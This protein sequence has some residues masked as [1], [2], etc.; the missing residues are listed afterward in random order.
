MSKKILLGFY[1]G[2]VEPYINN[3]E[4]FE[5][6]DFEVQI[7]DNITDDNLKE[8]NLE[9]VLSNILDDNYGQCS[10]NIIS[11]IEQLGAVF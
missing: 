4:K 1:E 6:D 3:L 2:S 7:F 8:F 11:N 9:N 5:E 10:I